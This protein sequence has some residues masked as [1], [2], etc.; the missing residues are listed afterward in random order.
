MDPAALSDLPTRS[1]HFGFPFWG[2]EKTWISPDADWG[3][4]A[5]YPVLDSTPYSVRRQTGRQFE[6]RSE[7]FRLCP[8][9]DPCFFYRGG[10]VVP[11][12]DRVCG[13]ISYPRT[14]RV[15]N[16]GEFITR[17][18]DLWAHAYD[19]SLDFSRP[20][21]PTGNGFIDAFNSKL[22][23]KCLNAP[24]LMSLADARE[25]P[26]DRRRHHIVD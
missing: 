9:A 17:D 26:E 2:G 14:T 13:R 16:G 25:E 22:R 21:K 19:V 5:P 4:A 18:L 10:D 8:A 7:V 12:L 1:P 3:E 11:T 24:W 6:L 20:G 15:D 23:A